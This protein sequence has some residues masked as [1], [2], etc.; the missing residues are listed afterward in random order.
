MAF[1]KRN[2]AKQWARLAMKFGL[3]LSDPKLWS[4][5]N[6]QL[7]ERANDVSDVV[8]DKYDMMREKYEDAAD[9]LSDASSALRGDSHW[10]APTLSFIGGIGV[11]VG[12]GILFAPASG[13]EVRGA[14]RDKAFDVK[15]NVKKKVNEMTN[16]YRTSGADAAFTG[17]EGD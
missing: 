14:I 6:D 17:T 1:G 12:L 15:N 4:T 11:G 7:K 5:L 9:R 10:L 8:N 3:V 13:E 2:T 16:R